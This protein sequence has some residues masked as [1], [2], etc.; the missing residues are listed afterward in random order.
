MKCNNCDLDDREP[1]LDIV[2]EVARVR[3]GQ[4][5]TSIAISDRRPSESDLTKRH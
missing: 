4:R 3:F 1:E 2:D 5:R